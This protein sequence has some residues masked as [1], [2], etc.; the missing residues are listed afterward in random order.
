MIKPVLS[1]IGA[2]FFAAC[3]PALA[4]AP[5]NARYNTSL[6]IVGDYAPYT[7]SLILEAAPDGTLR[8]YYNNNDYT[9]L[10]APVV[11]ARSGDDIWLDI[12]SSEILHIQGHVKDGVIEG[13]AIGESS[14]KIYSFSAKPQEAS[15][16]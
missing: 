12:E 1:L 7:G 9:T 10:F 13:G 16:L 8:G 3:V 14:Q 11:G 5:A 15:N 6:T 2:L 4:E